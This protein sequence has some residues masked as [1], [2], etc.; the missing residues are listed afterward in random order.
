MPAPE[1]LDIKKDSHVGKL[2]T[3]IDE[4]SHRFAIGYHTIL[5]RKLQTASA[6]DDVPGIGPK[7][8]ALL[9]RKIGSVARIR[10]T[11]IEELAKII[12]KGKATNIKKHL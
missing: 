6:L 9:K 10:E 7:T 1:V 3:R 4:E 12:G 8:K 2:I 5:K 11:P